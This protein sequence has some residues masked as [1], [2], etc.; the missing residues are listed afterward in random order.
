MI[1]A[2]GRPVTGPGLIFYSL[3]LSPC[4]RGEKPYFLC[5]AASYSTMLA[6]TPAFSDSTCGE[7][8]IANTSSISAINSFVKPPPSLPMKMASGSVS[9]AWS[10]G[11]PLCEDVAI[12]RNPRSRIFASAS[13][14]FARTIGKRNTEPA[15]ARMTLELNTLA[16]PSPRIAPLA[17][18]ASADLQDCSQVS[19]VLNSCNRQQR[20]GVRLCQYIVQREFLASHKRSYALRRI[21][22]DG[23]RE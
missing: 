10:T 9:L 16:V 22:G 8:G 5:R 6:A 11:M 2:L 21:A 3:W 4:L 12:N 14:S 7:C 1:P 13:W 23:A 18:N 20:P 15:E 17:P 19:R